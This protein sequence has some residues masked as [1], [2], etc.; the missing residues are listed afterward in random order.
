[1]RTDEDFVT[2]AP[3]VDGGKTKVISPEELDKIKRA[4]VSQRT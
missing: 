3:L 4:E 2:I 1:M